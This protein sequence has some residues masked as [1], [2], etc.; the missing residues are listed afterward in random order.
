MKTMD[1]EQSKSEVVFFPP[2]VASA[3]NDN[4]IQFGKA[5]NI[6]VQQPS[7]QTFDG[8]TIYYKPASIGVSIALVSLDL[9]PNRDVDVTTQFPDRVEKRDTVIFETRYRY[10]AGGQEILI[11]GLSSDAYTIV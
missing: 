3:I 9:L 5:L 8:I 2:V 4:E 7:G 11:D 10:S 1:T 6:T